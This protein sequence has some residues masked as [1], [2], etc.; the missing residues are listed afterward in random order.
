MYVP[1]YLYLK[2]VKKSFPGPLLDVNGAQCDCILNADITAALNVLNPIL[3]FLKSA[4]SPGYAVDENMGESI[5][6][7]DNIIRP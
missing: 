4:S 1:Y 7:N 2:V 3:L 6:S 5:T